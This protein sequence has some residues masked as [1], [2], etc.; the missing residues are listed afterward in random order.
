MSPLSEQCLTV[1]E[2]LDYDSPTPK[3]KLPALFS[4]WSCGE[5]YLS[6]LPCPVIKS[7]HSVIKMPEA[8]VFS[9]SKSYERAKWSCS[10]LQ[11]NEA[12]KK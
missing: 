2:L 8:W 6:R 3:P 12:E 10:A 11:K 1:R 7:A 4:E 5:S 9:S